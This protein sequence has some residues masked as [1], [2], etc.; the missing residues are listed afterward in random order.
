MNKNLISGLCNPYPENSNGGN[1]HYNV[2]MS[3]NGKYPAGTT[4]FLYCKNPHA[5]QPTPPYAICSP[6]GIWNTDSTCWPSN[7]SST[8]PGRQIGPTGGSI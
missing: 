7:A 6:D 2:P 8:E 5:D 3:E 4:A 1:T